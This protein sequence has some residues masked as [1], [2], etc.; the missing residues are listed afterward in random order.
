MNM[1]DFQNGFI[2]GLC[3]NGMFTRLTNHIDAS[4]DFLLDEMVKISLPTEPQRGRVTSIKSSVALLSD[5]NIE[6]PLQLNSKTGFNI[7]EINIE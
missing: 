5:G 6:I 2:M 1:I 4:V 3:S 7:I